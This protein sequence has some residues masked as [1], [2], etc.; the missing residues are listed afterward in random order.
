MK[1]AEIYIY[2]IYVH[3]LRFYSV[4]GRKE[5]YLINGNI[6]SF[7]YHNCIVRVYLCIFEYHKYIN[8]RNLMAISC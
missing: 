6:F 3:L 7:N 4:E 8:T 5:I 1:Y 2:V